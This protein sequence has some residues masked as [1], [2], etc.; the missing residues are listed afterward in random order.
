MEGFLYLSD[1]SNWND[2]ED[3]EHF[4]PE[5]CTDRNFG[6][7]CSFSKSEN[8]AMWM[9]YG[10][11]SH[12]GAMLNIKRNQMNKIVNENNKEDSFISLG[13]FKGDSF[14]ETLM[15]CKADY[16]IF[17]Q[18][19]LYDSGKNDTKRTIKRSDDK[20]SIEDI[21]DIKTYL[22]EIDAIQVK[23]SYPWN[24]ENE[25][26]LYISVKNYTVLTRKLQ[27]KCHTV[28]IKIPESVSSE[29]RQQIY[30]SPNFLADVQSKMKLNEST[31]G[32]SLAWDLCKKCTINKELQTLQKKT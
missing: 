31:L 16:E 22:Q 13:N 17:R 15:I 7:C 14:K 12:S 29:L 6:L 24:Y 18:D 9:L 11:V 28:R 5:G 10:G 1:G 30:R 32:S 2:L 27:E 21:W 23:K 25:C 4:N 26:R 3:R 8:V 20:C 19:I